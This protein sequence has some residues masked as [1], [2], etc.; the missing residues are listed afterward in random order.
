LCGPLE[1]LRELVKLRLPELPIPLD[2]AR[3]FAH[4]CRDERRSPHAPLTPDACEAGALED[5]DVLRR[6]RKRHV[7]AGRQ[8]TNGLL[9]GGEPRQDLAPHRV[10]ER[11]EGRIEPGLM[12]NHVV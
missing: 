1:V 7:E 4:R 12:V 8:L 11:G 6:R 2:P 3:G 5:A 9:T 10:R